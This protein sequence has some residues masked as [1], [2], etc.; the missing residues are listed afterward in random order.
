MSDEPMPLPR[1]VFTAAQSDAL[2]GGEGVQQVVD[3]MIL[4]YHQR[5]AEVAERKP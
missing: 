2:G 3:A 1:V 4:A 5:V